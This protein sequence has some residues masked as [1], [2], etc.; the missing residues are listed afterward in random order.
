[1]RLSRIYSNK[2]KIFHP[3][4]FRQGLNVILAEI[5]LPENRK[6]DTHNLGKTLLGRLIDFQF[7]L[8]RD[9]NFFLFKNIKLFNEFVFFVEIQLYDST[10]LTVRRSVGTPSKISFKKHIQA[11]QDFIDLPDDD[12]DHL[13]LTFENARTMMDSLLNWQALKPWNY[14]NAI[15]YQLRSQDDFQDV[16]QLKKFSGKHSEWKPLLAHMLG[17]NYQ[18]IT[19]YYNWS[20]D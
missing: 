13:D 6:K 5:R 18:L 11:Y 8:K 1:M 2:P 14:R 12:W 7:L 3:I 16:F 17:F 19:L 9:K 15:G 10:Y 20:L 4:D